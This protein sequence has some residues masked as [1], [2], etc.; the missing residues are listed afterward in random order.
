MPDL[1]FH[2]PVTIG[3]K[4][5][6]TIKHVNNSSA[7]IMGAQGSGPL[8]TYSGPLI[9]NLLR[10]QRTPQMAPTLADASKR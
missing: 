3:K 5:S 1:A 7:Q 10:I 4:K 9:V 8:N 6:A 2:P